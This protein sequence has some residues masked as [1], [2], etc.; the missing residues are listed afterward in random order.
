MQSFWEEKD[1]IKLQNTYNKITLAQYRALRE[2]GAPWAIPTIC[3]LTIKSDKKMN[4]HQAKSHIVVLG[5]YKDRI[6]LKSEKYA[7][8]LRPD[9]MRLILSMAVK[10]RCTLNQGDHKNVFCQGVFPLDEITIVKPP[11]GNLD[12]KKDKNWLLKH[13]LYG[14]RRSPCHWYTKIKS[15]L[16][17]LG[18]CQNAYDPS[19]F[20]GNIVGPSDPSDSPLAIPLT[21]GLYVDNFVYFSADDAVEAKFQR[22]LKQHVTVDFMGRV[23]WFLGTHFV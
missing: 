9:T 22:L 21:L 8:I 23:E 17:K 15:I 5:N 13:T 18:L 1:C 7:P 3:D 2:K 19:L 20:S 12:A 14:L 16:Q 11:I 10:Q 6:W 4:P